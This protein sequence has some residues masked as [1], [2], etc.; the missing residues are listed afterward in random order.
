MMTASRR[1]C[2]ERLLVQ[3]G[4]AQPF[5]LVPLAGG[6]NS[7]AFRVEFSSADPPLF[8]KEYFHH[9]DDPRDRLGTE[10][11]FA[12]FAWKQGLRMIAQPLAMD[13]AGLGALYSFL[14]GNKLSARAV[15]RDAIAQ[16]L[17]FFQ[18]LN[19]CKGS[20]QAA[21]LP[22]ASEACFSLD[23]HWHCLIR[24]VRRLEAIEPGSGIDQQ[25]WVFVHR[26]LAPA[27]AAY[28]GN[29]RDL[30]AA[31]GIAP[32]AR[33]STDDRCLS[34]SDFG[35]HNA[36]ADPDGALRF[37]DFEYA[38]WDDPA[39]LVCDFFCQPACPAP[40]EHYASFANQVAHATTDPTLQRMR[41]DLLLPMYRLKWCC[42]LLNDFLPSGG[43]RRRFALSDRD[44]KVRKAEQLRKAQQALAG[45]WNETP[46]AAAA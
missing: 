6:A 14:D 17:R 34:P 23:D 40:M 42:I 27:C 22:T 2:V 16:C 21:K 9:P 15:T 11:A 31:V 12:S 44:E 1:E 18:Q 13:R 41:M 5:T 29:A 35:F 45:Y 46:A 43:S 28:L 4:A 8:F 26:E 33:L 10:F 38:G 19:A 24:R 32:A 3:A 20:P 36:L 7:K 25:A 37:L 30:A 39:K